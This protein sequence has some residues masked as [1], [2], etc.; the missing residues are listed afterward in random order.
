MG[1]TL[2]FKLK[3]DATGSLSAMKQTVMPVSVSA[4]APG[5]SLSTLEFKFK[6]K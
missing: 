1:F 2:N 6:F 4:Q 3:L 5:P